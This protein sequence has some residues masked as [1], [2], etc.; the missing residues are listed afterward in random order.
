MWGIYTETYIH[1]LQY[2]FALSSILL[3]IIIVTCYYI[4]VMWLL[5]NLLNTDLPPK[6]TEQ[7]LKSVGSWSEFGFHP[8][9]MEPMFELVFHTL[10]QKDEYGMPRSETFDAAVDTIV[11]VVTHPDIHKYDDLRRKK[12][13]RFI[14]SVICKMKIVTAFWIRLRWC[15]LFCFSVCF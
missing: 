2:T 13:S 9:H 12:I 3:F 8:D 14:C 1:P 5:R 10:R 11:K 4:V 15:F 6:V 7:A